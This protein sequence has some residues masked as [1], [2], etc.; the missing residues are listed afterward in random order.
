MTLELTT[1]NM[2]A[3][4]SDGIGWITFN[5]PE[6]RNAINLEMAVALGDIVEHFQDDGLGSGRG[7]A[8]RWREGVRRW[9]GHLGVQ[10]KAFECDPKKRNTRRLPSAA[11]VGSRSWTKP[12]IALIEGYCIGG[13]LATALSADVRFASP[14]STFGVP[15]AKLGLGYGFDGI[16]RLAELVGP[17]TARDIMFS[18]RFLDADEALSKGLINFVVERNEIEQ[19]VHDYAA[20]IAS[21]APLTVRA[22]KAALTQYTKAP[23]ERD[24]D[25]LRTMVDA[26]FN[27]EDYQEG[28]RAFGE[29]R[30]PNFKG[31]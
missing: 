25:K 24:L 27:S 3:E 17:S 4:V 8:R 13:G 26:C 10:G 21:N 28:I 30:K 16:A 18:A 14:D 22:A 19:R 9:G 11:T 29:K 23:E 31:R 12:L 7:H 20:Q 1:T 2:L 6:K 5:Q 15:A